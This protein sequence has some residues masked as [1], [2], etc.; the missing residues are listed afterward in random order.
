MKQTT[1]KLI[2][3]LERSRRAGWA[4][5]FGKKDEIEKLKDENDRLRW[6]VRLLVKRI[7]FH[8][9]LNND[10]DLVTLAKELELSV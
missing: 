8:K 2:D 7:I 6:I 4:V 3:E 9:R 10:D 5:A 1:K